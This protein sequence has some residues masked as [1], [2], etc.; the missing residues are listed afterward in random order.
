MVKTGAAEDDEPPVAG[1]GP[2]ICSSPAHGVVA[3]PGGG[4]VLLNKDSMVNQTEKSSAIY[5]LSPFAFKLNVLQVDI[6]IGAAPDVPYD[7]KF[8][9][10]HTSTVPPAY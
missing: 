9:I 5:K 1:R 6:R 2:Q 7:C 10:I 8:S 4:T 3:Y